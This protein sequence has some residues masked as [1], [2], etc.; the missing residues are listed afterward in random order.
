M[1]LMRPL[2]SYTPNFK[3]STL[4]EIYSPE[5]NAFA[6]VEMTGGHKKGARCLRLSF[7]RALVNLVADKQENSSRLKRRE[8][9]ASLFPLH[10]KFTRF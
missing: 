6:S 1:P 9:S 3:L 4:S 2:F 10:V 7:C 5:V 8:P